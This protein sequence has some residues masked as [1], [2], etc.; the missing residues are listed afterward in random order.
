MRHIFTFIASLAAIFGVTF[1]ASFTNPLNTRDGS[2]PFIVHSGDGYYY[3]LTTT[4]SD[5]RITRSKTV[6]GLKTG[7]NKVVWS[8][9]TA[10]RCCNVWAPEVHWIDNAWWIYYTA[11]N[12]VNLD[13]Q[14]SFVLKG[15]ATP[16]DTY[17]FSS[18]LLT[19][20]SIDGTILRFPTKNYYVYSCIR[21]TLQ[22][23][24]IAPMTSP[25][26]LGPA[27]LL[28]KP[29]QSWETQGDFPVAEGPA[30]LYHNGKTYLTYSGSQ[31]W[32]PSYQ[33]GLLTYKGSG[34][35]TAAGS[36]TKSGPVFSSANGN[37]GTGHNGFF[38]SP[39]GKETWN[40]YH[41]TSNPAGACDG[42]RYTAAQK[43]NW[44][45]DGTPNFGKAVKPGQTVA[46]PSGEP[47]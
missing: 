34:D 10:S 31:C 22:S 44:N 38:T 17:T 15:G 36:W 16:W 8:D 28:T 46:G 3:L 41:A 13:G 21:D 2:D 25:S 40:V 19:E 20:W 33:L 18:Q 12:N 35:P 43:V 45:A 23:L 6:G 30:A 4:W 11:G 9:K 42:N 27:T 47:A 39:D 32:S 24:C 1:G 29:T 37:Y 26:T 5:I 14:R 7:E